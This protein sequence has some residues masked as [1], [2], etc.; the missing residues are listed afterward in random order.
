MFRPYGG[1]QVGLHENIQKKVKQRR[2]RP[3]PY[4][5]RYAMCTYLNVTS[6]YV[7]REEEQ[8][9]CYLVAVLWNITLIRQYVESIRMNLISKLKSYIDSD[10]RVHCCVS[11]VKGRIRIT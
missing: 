11:D 4:T 1:H 5:Y 8:F 10:F 6:I 2:K 9:Y 7:L 3:V